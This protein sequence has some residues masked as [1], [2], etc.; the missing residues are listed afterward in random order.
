MGN[1]IIDKTEYFQPFQQLENGIKI[2]VP[3]MYNACVRN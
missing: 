1:N 3:V 2:S